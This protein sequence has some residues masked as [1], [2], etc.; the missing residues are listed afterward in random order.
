MSTTVATGMRSPRRGVPRCDARNVSTRLPTTSLPGVLSVFRDV[1]FVSVTYITIIQIR[2]TE[3]TDR[4][5][6]LKIVEALPDPE[7][8][9]VPEALRFAEE[10]MWKR[11]W[12]GTCRYC[13]AREVPAWCSLSPWL[14]TDP[15]SAGP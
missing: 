9:N 10:A 12:S 14:T 3:V 5:M 4:K 8:K 11:C 2:G 1:T 6:I 7:P 15:R 13:P